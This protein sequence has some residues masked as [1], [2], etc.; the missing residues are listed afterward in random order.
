MAAVGHVG[1]E[2]MMMIPSLDIVVAGKGDWG[3]PGESE[4]K[5]NDIIAL[6]ADAV[7]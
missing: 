2:V 1:R 3:D 6:L 5:F 7:R 4:D